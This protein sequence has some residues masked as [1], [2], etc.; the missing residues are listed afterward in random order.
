MNVRVTSTVRTVRANCPPCNRSRWCVYSHNSLIWTAFHGVTL[1]RNKEILLQI[2]VQVTY[3]QYSLVH[4]YL[5]PIRDNLRDNAIASG[6]VG[7]VES[8]EIG[9]VVHLW[10]R[11]ILFS[12]SKV[13]LHKQKKQ[14]TFGTVQG[15]NQLQ[16]YVAVH[17][18]GYEDVYT[19]GCSR[20][21][22]VAPHPHA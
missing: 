4:A 3:S 8:D 17:L 12:A 9:S 18:H 22:P 7:T 20:K 6:I 5:W 11:T 21:R 10:D 1:V 2:A 19:R 14:Y 15:D 16:D 13:V